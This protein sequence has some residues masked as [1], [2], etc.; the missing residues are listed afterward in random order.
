VFGGEQECFTKQVHKGEED[1]CGIKFF[2]R[3]QKS[4]AVAVEIGQAGS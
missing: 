4:A 1:L 2:A 3:P